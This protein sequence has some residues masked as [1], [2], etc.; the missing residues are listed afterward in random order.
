MELVKK[1][2]DMKKNLMTLEGYRVSGLADE[3]D[4]YLNRI[5][6]GICFVVYEHSGKLIFGPSRFVGYLNNNVDAHHA[7]EYK[8]GRETNPEISEI[9]GSPPKEDEV[10]EEAY[11]KH[12]ESLGITPKETGPFGVKRKYWYKQS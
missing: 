4:F 12:C 7:N 1:W 8:D 3:V 5:K 9:L 2:E 11:K 6:K 10:L